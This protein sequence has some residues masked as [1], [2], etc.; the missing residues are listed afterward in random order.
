VGTEHILFGLIKNRENLPCKVLVSLGVDLDVVKRELLSL[1]AEEVL[2][3]IDGEGK[4]E[5]KEEKPLSD[6]INRNL[7]GSDMTI[8]KSILDRIKKI[9]TEISLAEQCISV[10][11]GVPSKEVKGMVVALRQTSQEQLR[12]MVLAELKEAL[13]KTRQM[14]I[15]KMCDICR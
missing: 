11:I 8:L 6:K 9:E 10:A 15:S 5:G 1:V 3:K 14:L 12:K 7:S 2:Q 13:V 4:R